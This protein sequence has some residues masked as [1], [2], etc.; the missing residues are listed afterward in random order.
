MKLTL[1]VF[2]LLNYII[3]QL[4]CCKN[5]QFHRSLKLGIHMRGVCRCGYGK[6][7]N[8]KINREGILI[9]Q[10]VCVSTWYTNTLKLYAA[11]GMSYPQPCM[12]ISRLSALIWKKQLER[13]WP[14]QTVDLDET[15]LVYTVCHFRLHLLNAITLHIVKPHCSICD[16]FL[17][18]N[19]LDIN[20]Q[21]ILLK[22]EFLA[23][24]LTDVFYPHCS[25]L[26]SDSLSNPI[27][28]EIFQWKISL[29]C[30][31]R[32]QSKY[33]NKYLNILLYVSTCY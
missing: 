4:F 20:Y 24:L 2:F 9:Y 31:F 29:L 15:S 23:Y 8:P 26:N 16:I 11:S 30:I 25:A 22:S 1:I 32:L 14:G 7:Q 19:L 5:C 33:L 21:L 13:V 27:N 18:S 12:W 3:K 6:Y 17:A 28:Q 10:C